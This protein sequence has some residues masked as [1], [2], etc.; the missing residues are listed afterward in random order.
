MRQLDPREI[1]EL[2]LPSNSPQLNSAATA[3][4]A[5]TLAASA[6]PLEIN[7]HCQFTLE[8]LI[9]I[10]ITVGSNLLLR[11]RSDT[12]W[13][14]EPVVGRDSDIASGLSQYGLIRT[15]EQLTGASNEDLL[16]KLVTTLAGHHFR[17]CD[18]GREPNYISANL[19]MPVQ[20]S[21]FERLNFYG[22]WTENPH[23]DCMHRQHIF[24]FVKSSA[25]VVLA[26]DGLQ[27]VACRWSG[28]W[29]REQ[30]REHVSAIVCPYARNECGNIVAAL[31]LFNCVK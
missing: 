18:T 30:T 5:N 8:P 22:Q 24:A 31:F 27:V 6:S 10:R 25:Y 2:K 26:Q 28:D 4:T 15:G 1:W 13:S 14:H 16:V 3:G 12:L 20:T 23:T 17:G 29:G 19:R 11:A 9:V 21:I 7:L